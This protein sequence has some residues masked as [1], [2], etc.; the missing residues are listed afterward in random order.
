MTGAPPPAPA[1]LLFDLD[2]TLVD[3]RGDIAASCNAALEAHGRAALPLRRIL[4]MVGDGARALVARALGVFEADAAVGPVLAT[5]Q[6]HYLAHP[7]EHT[8]LLA[9]AR[10]ILETAARAGLPCALVTNKPR[11]IALA[12]LDALGLRE[13][14]AA[15]WGAGDGPLKPAPDSVLAV[16]RAL[17][18]ASPSAWMIGDGPQD[19][20]AGKAAGAFTVGVFGIAERERLLG[21]RPDLLV[22]SL[23]ALLGY[24]PPGY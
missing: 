24:L 8:V 13:S 2:G 6:A 20:G 1:A 3:S 21:S 11:D 14:F 23:T 22:P 17:G 15:V 9:G 5:F 7:C 4:P 10:E 12:L 16:T 18:V 19:V